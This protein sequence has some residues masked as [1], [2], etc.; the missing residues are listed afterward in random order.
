M[1][2]NPEIDVLIDALENGGATWHVIGGSQVVAPYLAF[3]LPKEGD[4]GEAIHAMLAMDRAF[5]SS[6]EIREDVIAYAMSIGAYYV[7]FG[8]DRPVIGEGRTVQ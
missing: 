2:I 1:T 4:G 7:E 5:R 3:A 8:N 6:I